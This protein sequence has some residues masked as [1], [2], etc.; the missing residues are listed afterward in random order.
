MSKVSGLTLMIC[1]SALISSCAT[2]QEKTKV[3][4]AGNTCTMLQAVEAGHT[5]MVETLLNAG[6]DPDAVNEDGEPA[7]IIA[8]EAGHTD[9]VE[10]LLKEGA[11]PDPKDEDD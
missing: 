11:D 10:A 1:S 8:L 6:A 9:M 2:M 3:T 7:L 5:D 4:R